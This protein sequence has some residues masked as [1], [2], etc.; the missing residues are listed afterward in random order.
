M[1]FPLGLL[2]TVLSLLGDIF[3]LAPR[4]SRYPQ[5]HTQW[6]SVWPNQTL[7]F[8]NYSLSWLT[9]LSINN[10]QVKCLYLLKLAQSCLSL[11]SDMR[12][13]MG[14][15]ITFIKTTQMESTWFKVPS[16]FHLGYLKVDILWLFVE[17]LDCYPSWIYWIISWNTLFMRHC[18]IH[19][20]KKW[21]NLL[22]YR[23]CNSRNT[24]LRCSYLWGIKKNW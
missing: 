7:N 11:S 22:I 24:G 16:V 13:K 5:D 8:G 6:C 9:A 15:R 23:N 18:V 20:E 19:Q 4:I 3:W 10:N 12:A 1:N 2:L 21:L 14:F 17:E